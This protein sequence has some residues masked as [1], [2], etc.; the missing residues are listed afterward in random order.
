MYT[1]APFWA[2]ATYDKFTKE[3][4]IGVIVSISCEH[5]QWQSRDV[6][7]SYHLSDSRASS[8]NEGYFAFHIEQLRDL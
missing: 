6:T 3:R 1:L 2:K 4:Q 5:S 8:S 7:W